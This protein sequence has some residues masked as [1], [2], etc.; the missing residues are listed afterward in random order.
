MGHEGYAHRYARTVPQFAVLGS[1]VDLS[2][3]INQ[4]QTL[5]VSPTLI[6]LNQLLALS[7]L[8]LQ[9]LFQQELADN[10]ALELVEGRPCPVCGTPSTAPLCPFC[11]P[12]TAPPGKDAPTPKSDTSAVVDS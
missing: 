10:P 11:E 4:E 12:P 5:K 3:Q 8:E 9:Q 2:L 6:V 1:R 7:S